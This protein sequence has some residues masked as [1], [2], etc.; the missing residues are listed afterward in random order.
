MTGIGFKDCHRCNKSSVHHADKGEEG[1]GLYERGRN[2]ERDHVE[3]ALLCDAG[4]LIK[5]V[6]DWDAVAWI[7]Q[8]NGL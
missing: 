6:M 5:S 1:F 2:N 4:D 7:N 3:L 8:E